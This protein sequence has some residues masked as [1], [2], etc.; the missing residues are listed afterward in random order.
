MK[1]LIVED[2]KNKLLRL[3]DFIKGMK[4]LEKI[5][6]TEAN[7]FT[8]GIRKIN[9][10]RW[11]IIIL[12]MSLPTY[13]IT[14]RE[15]GGDKKPIAGKEIMKRMIHRNILIPVVIVTQ[16]E[17]FGENKITLDIL[18]EEFE[19]GFK[20]V[21]KGTIFYESDKWQD[22]LSQILRK[23]IRDRENND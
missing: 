3:K 6:F 9:E 15:N 12:D 2:N 1:I 16:F 5:E 19:N 21:W 4:F 17:T 11:D 23:L 7:S 20:K 14:H 22:D 13:D 18:N 10:K 8:S